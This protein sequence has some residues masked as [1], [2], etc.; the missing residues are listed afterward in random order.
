MDPLTATGALLGAAGTAALGYLSPAAWKRVAIRQLQAR[1]VEKGALVLT[2]DDG[3]G[4]QTTEALMDL[5]DEFD[6]PATFFLSGGRVSSHREVALNLNGRGHEVAA[7]GYHH[8]HAWKSWPSALRDD[9]AGGMGAA[10]SMGATEPVSHRPPFGKL[11]LPTWLLIRHRGARLSWW[12]HDSGDSFPE[13]PER[14]PAL[15][16]LDDGGGVALLHDLDR[17][18]LRNDFVLATTRAL[19]V[20]ARKRGLSVVRF[21]DLW[22]ES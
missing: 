9:F 21:R 13:L 22:P 17:S 11:V 1:C 19:L 5:L 7:H 16:L 4:P 14:S 15:D 8:L 10:I 2:Y 18:Q 20:G 12:T 6:A 3:P